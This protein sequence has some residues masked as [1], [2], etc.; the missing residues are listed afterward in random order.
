MNWLIGI[1]KPGLKATAAAIGRA[2]EIETAKTIWA[3]MRLQLVAGAVVGTI[4][5]GSPKEK[6]HNM[7]F[8]LGAAYLTMG[9]GSPF[10][11]LFWSMALGMA[12]QF[13]NMI[14]GVVKGYRGVLESR[15]AAAVPFSYSSIGM[16]QAFATLQYSKQRLA[17]AYQN[18]G[19][20]AA[21]FAARYTSR[22]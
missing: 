2:N 10:R 1:L 15:T 4:G 5:P 18:T 9:M 3:G 22:S 6:I 13:G 21:F 7:A 20:E 8:N 14:R 11:Q 19:S 16:D 17:D 12:P